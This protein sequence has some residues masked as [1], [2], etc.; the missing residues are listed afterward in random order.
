VDCPRIPKKS[1]ANDSSSSE[2]HCR[3][4]SHQGSV[5]IGGS[6]LRRGVQELRI[7]APGPDHLV[8]GQQAAEEAHQERKLASPRTH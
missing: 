1:W 8:E 5:R 6:H 3:A 4:H 2:T 7:E